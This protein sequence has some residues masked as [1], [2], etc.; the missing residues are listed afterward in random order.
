MIEAKA[1]LPWPGADERTV[2]EEMLRDPISGHWYECRVFVKKRVQIQAKNIPQDHWEDIVQEAMMRLGKSLPTFRYQCA[3][4]TWIFAIVHSCIIDAYRRLTHEGLVIVLLGDT[5]DDGEREGD[6]LLTNSSRTVEDECI[7]RDELRKALVALQEYVSTHIHPTRNARILEMV[8]LEGH[9]L[10]AA[11]AAVGCSA[12]V[13]G[14]VVRSAQ[15]YV[16]EK[17]GYQR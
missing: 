15:R 12:P 1:Y 6:A 10:E 17:L 16:R 8:L 14:Y 5:H 2:V 4:R 3:L 9:A 11:A 13:A 7:T